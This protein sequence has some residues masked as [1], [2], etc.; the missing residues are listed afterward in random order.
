MK[1]WVIYGSYGYTGNLIAE[2]A[3]SSG[4]DQVI[5]SGR[6]EEKLRKQSERLNLECKAADLEKPEELDDLLQNADVVLH[7]AGPFVHTW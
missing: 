4:E 3:A 6:D 7:C 1:K 5:L 2:L